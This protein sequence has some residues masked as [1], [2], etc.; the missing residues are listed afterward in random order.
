MRVTEVSR[1]ERNLTSIKAPAPSGSSRHSFSMRYGTTEVASLHS[2]I[3][4]HDEIQ[5]IW[6]ARPRVAD[7]RIEWSESDC[8]CDSLERSAI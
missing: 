4:L 1:C 7:E 6:R 3:L 5:H 8:N 2:F